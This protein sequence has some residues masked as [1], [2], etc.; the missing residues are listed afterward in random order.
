MNSEAYIGRVNSDIFRVLTLANNTDAHILRV[1][2]SPDLS[3]ARVFVN[4]GVEEM[5]H[6]SGYFRNELANNL[7]LRKIPNLRF[8]LDDGDKNTARVEEL[9]QQIKKGNA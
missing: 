5:E 7:R 8:L 1:E 3:S 9:L 2:A 4:G 6:A